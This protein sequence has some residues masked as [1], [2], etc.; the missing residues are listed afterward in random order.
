MIPAIALELINNILKL[1]ILIVEGTPVEQRQANARIWFW[2]WW[3]ATRFMLKL[4]KVPDEA[5]DSIEKAMK[6]VPPQ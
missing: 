3:P 4:G 1:V 5:L 2:T 6:E